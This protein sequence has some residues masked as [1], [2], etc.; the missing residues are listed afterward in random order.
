[1]SFME[2][3]I[4]NKERTVSLS[5]VNENT[6]IIEEDTFLNVFTQNE[7]KNLFATR[8]NRD[9]DNIP[10]IFDFGL[11]ITRRHDSFEEETSNFDNLEC[12]LKGLR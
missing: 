1:M 7:N 6:M 3:E 4:D 9:N 12:F 2:T 8:N 5:E 10:N 11:A